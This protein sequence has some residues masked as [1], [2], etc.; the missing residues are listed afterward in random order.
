[1][2]IRNLALQERDLQGAV[3]R[4]MT[5]T[6]VVPQGNFPVKRDRD[7]RRVEDLDIIEQIGAG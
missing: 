6:P 7:L 4:G 5:A 2:L 1:M 3:E